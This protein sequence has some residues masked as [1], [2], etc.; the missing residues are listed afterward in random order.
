MQ[1]RGN[2]VAC[3]TLSKNREEVINEPKT[4][5][6]DPAGTTQFRD[7]LKARLERLDQLR[8]KLPAERRTI[9]VFQAFDLSIQPHSS[10]EVL[11]WASKNLDQPVAQ[12]LAAHIGKNIMVLIL[13]LLVGVWNDNACK[14]AARVAGLANVQ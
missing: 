10:V 9:E 5:E 13:T 6:F 7:Q 11:A 4:Y 1:V 2:S 3:E 12:V 8:R 14:G